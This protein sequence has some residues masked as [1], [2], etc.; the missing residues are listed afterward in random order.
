MRVSACVTSVALAVVWCAAGCDFQEGTTS[1]TSR[2]GGGDDPPVHTVDGGPG[3]DVDPPPTPHD[4]GTVTPAPRDAGHVDPP[5]GGATPY[6]SGPYGTSVGSVMPDL[7][8]TT[9]DGSEITW[10]D[11]RSDTSVKVIVWGSGA[12][13]CGPCRSEAPK[14]SD[15]HDRYE[16]QGLFVIESLFEDEYRRMATTETIRQWESELGTTHAVWAE[17]DPPYGEAS[18]IPMLWVIDAETMEVLHFSNGL[19]LGVESLIQDALERST[20]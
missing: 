7:W 5:S 15:L 6:P 1:S 20:R 19:E 17:P 11:I 16:S 14:M 8:F 13:W 10:R 3:G 9:R 4:G 18:A 2:G 12:G